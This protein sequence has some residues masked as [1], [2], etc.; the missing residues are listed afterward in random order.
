MNAIGSRFAAAFSLPPSSF[1]LLALP[2][3]ID[4]LAWVEC[5]E[6]LPDAVEVELRIAGLDDEEEL[7]ARRLI[8]APHV[9]DGVIRHRQAVEREHAEDRGER[10]DEDRAFE[11][12]GD[13][14]RPRVVRLAADVE[15][16]ADD[17]GVPAHEEAGDPAD[18]A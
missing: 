5:L 4:D 6:E 1:I 9:E 14:G 16:I 18:D 7:V 12:D 3:N 10:G 2:G 17:F 15:W 8:E 13:P 11:R